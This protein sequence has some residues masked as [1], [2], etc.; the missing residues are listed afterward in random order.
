MQ[1]H[2]GNVT[3]VI[4]ADVNLRP[5]SLTSGA[6]KPQWLYTAGE[7]GNIHVYSLETTLLHEIFFGHAN[8]IQHMVLQP[9]KPGFP[10]PALLFSSDAAGSLLVF[11]ADTGALL[12]SFRGHRSAVSYIF[13]HPKLG[14]MCSGSVDGPVLVWKDALTLGAGGGDGGER[15]KRRSSSRAAALHYRVVEKERVVGGHNGAVTYIGAAPQH[16]ARVV[17]ASLDGTLRVTNLDSGRVERVVKLRRPVQCA[18]ANSRAWP[19]LLLGFADGGMGRLQ[20]DNHTLTGEH[21]SGH[22]GLLGIAAHGFTTV[23]TYGGRDG[24][25]KRLQLD[26]PAPPSAQGGGDVESGGPSRRS[27]QGT[28]GSASTPS[29]RVSLLK[30]TAHGIASPAERRRSH[31]ARGDKTESN[32]DELARS[33]QYAELKG[34]NASATVTGAFPGRGERVR[35]VHCTSKHEAWAATGGAALLVDLATKQVLTEVGSF[36]VEFTSAAISLAVSVVQLVSLPLKPYFSGATR[37][38]METALVD[39]DL[40]VRNVQLSPAVVLGARAGLACLLLLLF[41]LWVY[42]GTAKHL[43]VAVC[44]ADRAVAVSDERKRPC[45][46]GPRRRRQGC[47]RAAFSTVWG[48]LWL[49]SSVGIVPLVQSVASPLACIGS[50]VGGR[51]DD[52]SSTSS[53]SGELEPEFG[54]GAGDWIDAG[55]ACGTTAH[56]AATS[57]SVL[58]LLLAVPALVR[59]ARVQS[60]ALVLR[61]SGSSRQRWPERSLR[62]LWDGSRDRPQAKSFALQVVRR[63]FAGTLAASRIVIATAAVA[64]GPSSVITAALTVAASVAL[65]V[66]LTRHPPYAHEGANHANFAAFVGTLFSSGCALLASLSSDFGVASFLFYSGA[67][68]IMVVALAFRLVPGCAPQSRDASAPSSGR[69]RRRRFCRWCRRWEAVAPEERRASRASSALTSTVPP[70]R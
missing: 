39:S 46:F 7:D 43:S 37:N 38:V 2:A 11:R 17:T 13:P 66:T 20:W 31:L 23:V 25:V 58:L 52:G 54:F 34:R 51:S 33:V 69:R 6:A 9:Q 56:I 4:A 60:D 21:P 68:P 30:S 1:G 50:A 70:T 12:R 19:F 47:L 15:W 26:V 10:C 40:I 48:V 57:V 29:R 22:D 41:L 3:C 18:I 16:K 63:R 5:I 49:C 44:S 27:S 42:R 8:A 67:A 36:P 24:A 61:R 59:M 62:R 28:S 32:L 14:L 64:V 53:P 55:L 45:G 35:S 65:L